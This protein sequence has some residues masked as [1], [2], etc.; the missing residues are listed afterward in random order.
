MTQTRS[1]LGGGSVVAVMSGNVVQ[2][3]ELALLGKHARA[4]AAIDCGA[5]L[6]L[7]LPAPYA[8]ASA[9]RFA[10][11]GVRLLAATGVVTHLSFGCECGDLGLLKRTAACLDSPPFPELLKAE[12]TSGSSF[13]AARQRALARL[14]PEAAPLLS[15]PN[16]TLAVEYLRSISNEN[17]KIVPIAILRHAAGHDSALTEGRFA[18]ASLIR[19]M[20]FSGKVQQIN[21]Y[22]PARSCDIL[23]DEISAGR[24]PVSL[25]NAES[26]LLSTLRSMGEGEF[27]PLEGAG[28][29]MYLRFAR[30][31]AR[32]RTLGELYSLAK[33]K[34][35]THSRVRRMAL[36][37]WLGI[38]E[39]TAEAPPPYLRVLAANEEGR[40]LLRR[41]SREASL[42]VITKP[43]AAKKIGGRTGELFGFEAKVTDQYALMYPE[44]GERA[45]GQ[46]WTVGPAMRDE[47]FIPAQ[48]GRA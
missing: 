35:Y 41:M 3:G 27:A 17:T 46:E 33:T 29:G 1:L 28:E 18:S 39:E 32:A 23:N 6:V 36:H 22:M 10:R 25:A 48:P 15:G 43:A 20:I 2:R 30:A 24:A 45:G 40:A 11:A 4:R 31:A 42:P 38:T 19:D 8:C 47:C 21:E 7:E 37:A 44:V 13:P 12:L 9:E 26:A 16:N 5:D 14:D 34:R